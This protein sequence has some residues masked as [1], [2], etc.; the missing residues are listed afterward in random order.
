MTQAPYALVVGEALI[1]IVEAQ[2]TSKEIP[3]GSPANVALTLSRLGHESLLHTWLGD[4]AR[5]KAIDQHLGA[6]GVRLTPSSF[7]A[8]RTSTALAKIGSTGAA[9]YV[10]DVEW[11]PVPL[12][13]GAEPPVL[14]H[15]GSIAAVLAPG[16]DV[17]ERI[18]AD[19]RA[20]STI[21][22]DPNARPQL[23]GDAASARLTV[24]RLVALAD[25]VKV[26]DEDLA[27]LLGVPMDT[28]EQVESAARQWLELGPAIVVVT[29]GKHGALAVAASGACVQVPANPA[30]KVLDTVGAGD[31]FMGGLNSALWREG[32]LGA[33][34]RA[35]LRQVDQTQLASIV[36]LAAAV[37]DIT[38]SR[39]G[40]NPPTA[41]ELD[42]ALAAQAG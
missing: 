8:E 13:A 38:V 15:T 16:A 32:L 27:W 23:M 25:L 6:S 11:A 24:E 19:H 17:V 28:A 20:T 2:G 41:A 31:S 4:D 34:N 40:A 14:V 1:D 39:A 29:R 36:E 9:T 21:T 26:S 35:A 37:A 3:G 42:A 7:G 18:L 30:V 22:Y 10:F 33:E 12:P 5:G